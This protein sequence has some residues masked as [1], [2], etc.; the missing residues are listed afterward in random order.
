VPNREEV[1]GN[2]FH[3]GMTALSLIIVGL[4][5]FR[6]EDR[7]RTFLAL[8]CAL[9]GLG[10]ALIFSFVFRWQSWSTR[11][12]I[13]YYVIFAPVIGM[14]F[15]K[16]LPSL[17]AWLMAV[18]LIVVL[19]NPLLNNYSRAFSWSD[20]N[21]N[22]IWRLSR[23]GLLF[24]NNPNIE[25][26]VLELTERMAES[27]CRDYGI[28]MR[29][30]APEYILWGTLTPNPEAYHFEHIGV[31]NPTAKHLDQAFDPCGVVLFEMS[32]VDDEVESAYRL[33][34]RWMIGD[35]YPFSLYL[36]PEFFDVGLE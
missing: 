24:A 36:K 19:V 20:Q 26:A 22:S 30:N 12:F 7:S 29:E 33:A 32:E 21:R 14:V 15:G 11:F 5:L 8:L 2:P 34:E 28:V 10:V 16:L 17:S 18:A 6:K 31:Q 1:A 27:G 23:K 25:G 3:F 13:P 4:G 35:V 9:S